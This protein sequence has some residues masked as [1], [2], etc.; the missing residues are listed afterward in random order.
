MKNW[1]APAPL[2]NGRRRGTL[3]ATDKRMDVAVVAILDETD[4]VNDTREDRTPSEASW[5]AHSSEQL[6]LEV[7][8]QLFNYGQTDGQPAVSRNVGNSSTVNCVI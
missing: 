3:V 4:E 7:K 2:R 5:R 1:T 8:Q 6:K